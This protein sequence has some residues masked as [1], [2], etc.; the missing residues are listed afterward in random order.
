MLRRPYVMEAERLRVA[1]MRQHPD[2][3]YRPRRKKQQA[4]ARAA[5]NTAASATYLARTEEPPP[6]CMYYCSGACSAPRTP[7]KEATF[8]Q[9]GAAMSYSLPSTPLGGGDAHFPFE[10]AST[11][12]ASPTNRPLSASNGWPQSAFMYAPPLNADCG[13][14]TPLSLSMDTY[15]TPELSPLERS[16][17]SCGGGGSSFPFQQHSQV[18]GQLSPVAHL[19]RRFSGQSVAPHLTPPAATVKT[20]AAAAARTEDGFNLVGTCQRIA[21]L[22]S[23]VHLPSRYADVQHPL[24]DAYPRDSY[25]C[26]NIYGGATSSESATSESSGTQQGKG[27]VEELEQFMEAEQLHEV[28]RDEFDQYLTGNRCR[29]RSNAAS[30]KISQW[31]P[32]KTRQQPALTT[33]ATRDDDDD[34][35]GDDDDSK[36]KG[37]DE[38]EKQSSAEMHM[39]VYG[40]T[41]GEGAAAADESRF[42]ASALIDALSCA[43]A[44]CN[45]HVSSGIST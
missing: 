5:A 42:G 3:K 10:V 32:V 17:E 9:Y 37:V 7:V 38:S 40:T 31:S 21:S 15:P 6:D 25:P 14:T 1:H 13:A 20:E 11:P 18:N 16:Y 33:A 41:A 27:F 8:L 44:L 12:D 26:D 29:F 22:Q 34:G 36:E 28:D 23:L 43:S 2:Y 19:L 30:Y 45:E 35:D 24:A 4:R 39:S